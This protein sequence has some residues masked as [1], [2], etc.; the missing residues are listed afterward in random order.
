MNQDLLYDNI[1]AQC[2][3]FSGLDFTAQALRRNLD[4]PSE[5]LTVSFTQAYEA[6]LKKYHSIVVRPVFGVR[7]ILTDRSKYVRTNV[8][9]FIARHEGLPLPKGL[10]RKDWC[11]DRRCFGEDEGMDRGFRI[12]HCYYQCC[13]QG[14]PRIHQG[15]VKPGSLIPVI[16]FSALYIIIKLVSFLGLFYS[17]HQLS[18]E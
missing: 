11:P 6:T 15:H 7:V 3:F 8:D 5:E 12:N 13:F 1:N 14:T 2:P 18:F 17:F 10:L 16:K 4:N 9:L